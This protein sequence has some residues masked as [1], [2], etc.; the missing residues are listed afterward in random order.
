MKAA[1]D[2]AT[3]MENTKVKEIRKT[4]PPEVYEMLKEENEKKNELGKYSEM[5]EEFM[6]NVPEEYRSCT[7]PQDYIVSAGGILKVE[8]KKGG[9]YIDIDN[10]VSRTPILL[11]NIIINENGMEVYELAVLSHNRWKKTRIDASVLGSASDTAKYLK[12]RGVSITP[13]TSRRII[14]YIDAMESVNDNTMEPIE[15]ITVNGW[16]GDTFFY[17]QKKMEGYEYSETLTNRFSAVKNAAKYADVWKKYYDTNIYT[18]IAF[19][20]ALSAPFLKVCEIPN[21]IVYFMG[22]S[23]SGKSCLCNYAASAWY[24]TEKNMQSFNTTT[25]GLELV[26]QE[27]NDL[28]VFLDER[29]EARGTDKKQNENIK[30]LIYGI[31]QG[32][33]RTRGTKSLT[34]REQDKTR[35]VILATGEQSLVDEESVTAGALNR[36]ICI[37]TIGVSELVDEDI[38]SELYATAT[39]CY[40][41]FGIG[42]VNAVMDKYTIEELKNKFSDFCIEM[43]HKYGDGKNG[44][45]IRYIVL[46]AF[47][48][49]LID[50]VIFG[51]ENKSE[52]FMKDMLVFARETKEV[53]D[54]ERAKQAILQYISMKAD[55]IPEDA[56]LIK[57]MINKDSVFSDSTA[58][59]VNMSDYRGFYEENVK[60]NERKIYLVP[61]KLK[62]YM[63]KA[64]FSFSK[65]MKEL[66]MNGFVEKDKNG[67]Y[68]RK[69]HKSKI[70]NYGVGRYIIVNVN[71][72]DDEEAENQ[73]V[74]QQELGMEY[75]GGMGD[76]NIDIPF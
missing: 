72:E 47:V 15:E 73:D 13:T 51:R 35:C 24:N 3:T 27:F 36:Y 18:K 20:A 39:V 55:N 64:G 54:A 33:G 43:I 60:E 30:N 58:K 50:E 23:G 56:W 21:F 28:P 32:K 19:T 52:D 22:N 76:D 1:L 62:E 41:G 34:V 61:C 74:E 49:G 57:Q 65:V 70:G 59:S 44:R 42:F 48:G 31:S 75:N 17:P 38:L 5:Q 9:D 37:D 40:G 53:N 25:V 71:I 7:I 45:N 68:S 29:Q 69:I 6:E 2:A 4:M 63:E 26:M 67:E 10:P 8:H 16:H 12:A 14:D 11:V 66:A 46:L